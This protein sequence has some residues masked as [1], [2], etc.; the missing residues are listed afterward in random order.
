MVMMTPSGTLMPNAQRHE[1]SVV[2]HPPSSGPTAAMPPIVDPHTANAMP[3]S[4]PR[5]VAFSSERV[6]GSIIAP[7]TPCTS[8]ARIS[9]SPL[10]AKAAATDDR[11][12]RATPMRRS[13]RRP[14]RSARLP[15]RSRSEAKTR[16][17]ASCTHCTCVE[18]M[19][20]SSTIAGIATLTIVES[21]MISA[22]AR[23]MKTRPIQR[24][25]E[26]SFTNS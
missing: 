26:R 12:N 22:T 23:L 25:D 7:P 9:R 17:Y 5:N 13:R 19:S 16:V 3:R 4:R 10:G 1:K 14:N 11:E 15:N 24:R 20:R 18:E 6:L 2:S 8:R 21:T